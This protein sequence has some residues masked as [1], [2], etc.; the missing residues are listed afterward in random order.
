MSNLKFQNVDIFSKIS[1]LRMDVLQRLAS[2]EFRMYA[3]INPPTHFACLFT[4]CLHFFP[5][6]SFSVWLSFP[7]ISFLFLSFSSLSFLSVHFPSFPFHSMSSLPDECV[8]FNLRF[9]IN[10]S[11]G[12]ALATW[13]SDLKQAMLVDWNP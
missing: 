11:F 12:I 10:Y 2:C 6:I 13:V 8:C 3:S 7:L 9:F 4:L 5:C 1:L